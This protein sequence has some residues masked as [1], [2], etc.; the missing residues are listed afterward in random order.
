MLANRKFYESSGHICVDTWKMRRSTSFPIVGSVH[1]PKSTQLHHQ[2][3]WQ[4]VLVPAISTMKTTHSVLLATF[5][6]VGFQDLM[7]RQGLLEFFG[8]PPFVMGSECCGKVVEIGEGVTEFKVS[9][10]LK[11]SIENVG[12]DRSRAHTIYFTIYHTLLF[13]TS[14]KNVDLFFTIFSRLYGF[15]S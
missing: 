2:R 9:I 8:K 6:G 3:Y 12:N 13:K 15:K 11:T 5:S 10:P 14:L 4:K 1:V 7:T